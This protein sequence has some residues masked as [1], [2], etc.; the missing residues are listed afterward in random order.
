MKSEMFYNK[1]D[2]Y[3]SI[4]ELI[5]AIDKYIEYY[6]NERIKVKLNGLT[7]IQFRNQSMLD[8]S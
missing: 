4:D 3:N 2:V 6:N 5:I 7:P 1:D 8:I